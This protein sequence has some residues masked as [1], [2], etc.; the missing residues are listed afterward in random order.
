MNELNSQHKNIPYTI[1]RW[2]WGAFFLNV[3]W[4]IRHGVWFGLWMFVPVVNIFIPFVL[5]LKGNE[6]AWKKNNYS[7]AEVFLNSQRKWAKSGFIFCI[8]LILIFAT[9]IWSL[10]YTINNSIRSM[11]YI[12]NNSSSVQ[13]IIYIMNNN[14]RISEFLGAPIKKSGMEG[15]IEFEII[16][17]I[18]FSTVTFNV[19]GSKKEGKID[20]K[21][22]K[23]NDQ[24]I[25]TNFSIV[26]S[27]N[28]KII[29]IS[30]SMEASI[31]LDN[32]DIFN[33]DSLVEKI[34]KKVELDDY[35][36]LILIRSKDFNDF[37]QMAVDRLSENELC[38]VLEYSEGY[39][40]KNKNIFATNNT[41]MKKDEILPVLS[42]YF[43]GSDNFKQMF[44]W[45]KLK[46]IKEYPNNEFKFIYE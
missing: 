45:K 19:K 17:G 14:T 33:Y 23:K 11:F 32:K 18:K 42:S 5:G 15:K 25:V 34:I 36:F 13:E 20:A 41:C 27:D 44:A 24:T 6:W 38:Y 22:I 2:N 16:D 43:S 10:F 8:A 37:M 28:N 3:I 39:T 12:I 1:K 29:F 40:K 9:L 4:A 31:E 46:E 21:L 7:S 35:G 26:D 30:S